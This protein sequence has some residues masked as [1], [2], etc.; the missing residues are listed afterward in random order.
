MNPVVLALIGFPLLAGFYVRFKHFDANALRLNIKVTTLVLL[1]VGVGYGF[2]TYR[3]PKP[4]FIVNTPSI[5]LWGHLVLAI[6][7][8]AVETSMT[9]RQRVYVVPGIAVSATSVVL[10]IGQGYTGILPTLAAIF[11]LCLL[12]LANSL[13]GPISAGFAISSAIHTLV[14]NGDF[15]GIFLWKDI[16]EFFDI[17][18]T[19]MKLLILVAA[20]LAGAV[21]ALRS[22]FE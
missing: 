21:E 7:L 17:S 4:F 13:L 6:A 10:A 2:M 20:G 18:S 15:N 22:F 5:L 1:A 12:G 16:F 9:S 3:N 8:C 11:M 19:P 14:V